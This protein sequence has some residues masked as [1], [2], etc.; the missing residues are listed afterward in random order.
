MAE[1]YP[2]GPQAPTK[3]VDAIK[4]QITT[5]DQKRTDQIEAHRKRIAEIDDTD[6]QLKKDL[7]AAQ[8]VVDREHREAM[9][10][11]AARMMEKALAGSGVDI[12]EA[13][14]TGEFE[15]LLAEAIGKVG[16]SPSRRKSEKQGPA[17]AR[18]EPS[19]SDGASSSSEKSGSSPSDGVSPPSEKNESPSPAEP[20]AE[21]GS[22]AP[23]GGDATEFGDSGGGE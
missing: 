4:R 15:K 22:S 14:K 1:T 13:L 19:R 6:R 8:A 21:S 2:W 18:P 12:S 16:T 5:N 17:S 20:E 11:A 9:S 10:A 3:R 23:E 7:A